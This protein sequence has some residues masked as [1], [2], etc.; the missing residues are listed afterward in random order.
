M[1]SAV[2][3]LLFNR[4][5]ALLAF[6]AMLIGGALIAADL[7]KAERKTWKSDLIEIL[8]PAGE[9]ALHFPSSEI[10]QQI[11]KAMAD[12][13]P[14]HPDRNVQSASLVVVTDNQGQAQFSIKIYYKDKE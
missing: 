11:T 3:R 9:Y 8:L 13:A 6:G 5:T 12:Y 4:I 2:K 1:Q 7:G 14:V 10:G